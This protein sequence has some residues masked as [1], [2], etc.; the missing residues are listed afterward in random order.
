MTRKKAFLIHLMISV[1]LCTTLIILFIF[2]W[3]PYPYFITDGGWRGI[4]LVVMVDVILGPLLTFVIF[5]TKKSKRELAIDLTIIAMIQLS[6][7]TIGLWTVSELRTVAVVFS[8][9]K[10]YTLKADE[11]ANMGEA[12]YKIAEKQ[13][14]RPPLLVADFP[15]DL[16]S[17]QV[18]RKNALATGK[19]LYLEVDYFTSLNE[20]S[21]SEIENTLKPYDKIFKEPEGH[22]ALLEWLKKEGGKP[23]DY[24]F[25]PTLCQL[26][27]FVLILSKK[28]LSVVGYLRGHKITFS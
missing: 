7:L 18:L 22:E 24:Y 6:A 4:K 21:R 9:G 28:D 27:D 14:T 20:N 2:L 23:E 26:E 5:N 3:F 8:E 10:F 17:R 25:I 12:F 15:D 11:A 13:K 16:D 1:A 19:T